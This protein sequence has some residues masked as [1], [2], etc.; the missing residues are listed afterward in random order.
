[1]GDLSSLLLPTA[2]AA[3]LPVGKQ[4]PVGS[5]AAAASGHAGRLSAALLSADPSAAV[6]A[7]VT[8]PAAAMISGAALTPHELELLE[9]SLMAT[10]LARLQQWEQTAVAFGLAVLGHCPGA[11]LLEQLQASLSD[12]CASSDVSP[13]DLAIRAWALALTGSL[14]AEGWAQLMTCLASRASRLWGS[15][16]LDEIACLFLTH[17]AMMMAGG[18]GEP[19]A[20]RADVEASLRGLP[21]KLTRKLLSTYDRAMP[22]SPAV[23][24]LLLVVMHAIVALPHM[25]ANEPAATAPCD[26]RPGG[27]A[28]AQL[29]AA[30]NP[31]AATAAGAAGA[32][33]GLGAASSSSS[34]GSSTSESSSGSGGGGGLAARRPCARAAAA[35]AAPHELARASRDLSAWFRGH[36]EARQRVL[37]EATHFLSTRRSG[38][39]SGGVTTAPDFGIV[40]AQSRTV[41][42]VNMR[43]ATPPGDGRPFTLP[44]G[45]CALAGIV[46]SRFRP[47]T[48]AVPLWGGGAGGSLWDS[49]ACRGVEAAMVAAARSRGWTVREL[50]VDAWRSLRSES[51]KLSALEHALTG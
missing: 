22:T 36:D 23:L 24:S 13:T 27:D 39:G 37:N 48:D 10:T 2:H 4:P 35:A 18:S 50:T 19:R 14:P 1:M 30:L 32:S 44:G 16:E 15:S 34:S 8:A 7:L 38:G 49:Q 21:P 31:A 9:Q 5:T 43:G 51:D 47:S 46:A 20:S 33:R 29:R 12:G 42:M 17:A 6:S 40:L 11:A 26:T 3:A 28:V 25:D 45:A 41:L